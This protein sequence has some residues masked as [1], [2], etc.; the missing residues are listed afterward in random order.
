[1]LPPTGRHTYNAP[2]G[3]FTV[4]RQGRVHN[5]RGQYAKRPPRNY[6]NVRGAGG[7]FRQ[8][9]WGQP[10]VTGAGA[11]TAG[12]RYGRSRWRNLARPRFGRPDIGSKLLG[13][14]WAVANGM[15]GAAG[16][17]GRGARATGRGATRA[18]RYYTTD[19]AGQWALARGQ[20]KRSRYGNRD[21]GLSGMSSGGVGAGYSNWRATRARYLGNMGEATNM[22]EKFTTARGLVGGRAMTNWA[23]AGR[24]ISR[25]QGRGAIKGL[26]KAAYFTPRMTKIAV[27][28]AIAGGA[29]NHMRRKKEQFYTHYFDY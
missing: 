14:E 20:A 16:A 17:V 27:P 21:F 2:A 12:A 9:G 3:P 28:L 8:A 25:G 11:Q 18:S 26:A 10:F 1:M 22:R 29:F 19:K 23:A 15:I 6:Y 24:A 7:Q 5:A 4:D 13:A